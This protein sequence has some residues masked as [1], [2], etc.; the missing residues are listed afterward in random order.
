MPVETRLIE[1]DD[2]VV[3]PSEFK[4]VP[5]GVVDEGG[6]EEPSSY[7]RLHMVPEEEVQKEF[8]LCRCLVNWVP[9]DEPSTE[10][11]EAMQQAAPGTTAAKCLLRS[12][13]VEQIA[14][15][16]VSLLNQKSSFII[17]ITMNCLLPCPV[18]RTTVLLF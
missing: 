16:M 14:H 2:D 3:D 8:A 17:I 9:W 1:I 4:C 7:E 11:V 10:L 5:C 15:E 6:E 18:Y 13:V 12:Q